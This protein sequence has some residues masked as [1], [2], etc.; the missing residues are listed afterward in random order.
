MVVEGLL[1]L[2]VVEGVVVHHWLVD[3]SGCDLVVDL[4]VV[5]HHWLVDLVVDLGVVDLVGV[6]GLVDLGGEVGVVG[7]QRGTLNSWW[8]SV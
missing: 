5:V 1:D 3:G 4:G 2:V 6:D 7:P 8:W